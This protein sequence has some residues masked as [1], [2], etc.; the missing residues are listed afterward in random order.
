MYIRGVGSGDGV[1]T[2]VGVGCGVDVGVGFG[3]GV[4]L[5]DGEALAIAASV[6]SPVCGDSTNKLPP[7]MST[8]HPIVAK[9]RTFFVGKRSC[10]D[11]SGQH[12]NAATINPS[13]GIIDT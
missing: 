5:G 8:T 2:G 11:F 3:V 6:V 10:I 1:G 12:R 7:Q 4:G 13:A 9:I